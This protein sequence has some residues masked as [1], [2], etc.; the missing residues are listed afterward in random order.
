M[1][2]DENLSITS[3]IG[4][5]ASG[6]HCGLK[7][8]LLKKDLALIYSDVVANCCGVYTKNKVKGAPLIVTKQHLANKKAQ[9]III[10][11]GNANTC[12]G[13]DGLLKSK[14]M[15][16]LCSKELN[17]KNDDVLVASTG[18][19]GV[20]LNIDA[21]KDK[22]PELVNNLSNDIK[23]AKD[24]SMAIM[25]TDTVEKQAGVEFEIDG[26]KITISAMAKGSGMIHPNMATMLSFITT[27]ISIS[28]E[29]LKEALKES[30][31]ISY[32][33]VSV[34]GDSSTNDMVLIMANGLA[35][36]KTITEKNEDYNLFLDALI[37]LNIHIS[38]KIAKDG[39]G[40][41]KLIECTVKNANSIEDAEAL[42]KS[43][44]TSSLVKAAIFGSDANW[45]RILC[46]L[47][48]SNV[49]FDPERVD[50]SFA[51]NA[52]EI[53]VCQ[54]GSSVNFDESKAK[55]IL[56]QDEIKILIN[57]KLA[58]SEATTW[59]CDLTYDYVKINGDYRS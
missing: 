19:I 24:A 23:S 36:N 31:N 43:V 20:P 1:K 22:I 15:T 17:I 29:L 3:P 54:N 53:L 46:A 7:K 13:D 44:I 28:P 4:F 9:A 16:K 59:G 34:D 8:S 41:T 40:A 27:D 26:K 14:K 21:I 33:R 30:V 51:S 2:I 45:G 5:K 57:M 52:G 10:N 47:G 49:D 25:T 11:S 50:V 58:S 56:L 18:I 39:E 42:S 32:N 55:E 37:T 48:Y 6:I 38:K 12:N 35:L